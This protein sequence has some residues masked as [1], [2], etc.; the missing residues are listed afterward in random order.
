MRM[1]QDGVLSLHGGESFLTERESDAFQVLHGTVLVYIV[2]IKQ[3]RPGR[4]S[5]LYQAEER[6]VLPAFACRDLE[7]CDWRF[8]FTALERAELRRIEGGSTRVLRERFARKARVRNF[9]REGYNGGLVDQ[10]RF[11]IVT[12]DGFIR[13]TQHQKED[14]SEATLSLLLGA[15]RK[16]MP[17]AAEGSDAPVLYRALQLLCGS[18]KIP[19]VPYEKLKEAC[20]DGFTVADAARLSRFACREIVLEPGWERADGGSFLAFRDNGGPVVCLSRGTHRY[21]LWDV[22]NGCALPGTKE[23]HAALSPK[24][25]LLYPPLPSRSLTVRDLAR[26]CLGRIR[27]ADAVQL[28]LLTLAVSLLG[29]VTPSISQGIYDRYIP[30]GATDVLFQLG[31]LLGSFMIANILL[32]I[33]KNI[34]GYRLSSRMA[35]DAQSAIYAR[36]FNL[37]ESFFRRFESADLA[38]RVMTAGALVNNVAGVA[39]SAVVSLVT[40][41]VCLIRMTGCSPKLT[42][43]GVLMTAL[44]GALSYVISLRAL[45]HQARAAELGGKTGSILF[46]FLNGIAKIRIAGVEE[47][48]VY[49][50]LRPYVEERNEEEKKKKILDLGAVLNLIS[51]SL[52]TAVFYILIIRSGGGISLGAFLAFTTLFGTF[53]ACFLQLVD[54]LVRC[55]NERPALERLKPVLEA[56]PEFDEG[57]ELPG[58]LTGSIE[59]N[60]VSF[61]YDADAPLVLDGVS[62]NIR[63]GEYVG[64]VGA[65]GCGKSTLLKL[66]LGFET[67]TAG[68]IYYDNKDIESVDKRELRKK[69]GVVLQDGKLISG[70]IFENI[71]ITAPKA[72]LRD[73]NAV[74]AAVGLKDDIAAMPMGLHTILSE[75]CRTISGGQQQRILIARAL[76]GG[77]RILFFDEATSALDNVTQSMVCDALEKMD[78]TRVVIAHRLSTVIRCDRIVVLDRGRVAEQGSYDELMA[79]RGLFYQLASRQMV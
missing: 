36:L 37:P 1:N 23:V 48:A 59:I 46:Q 78:A 52:F 25:W 54:G 40:L 14:V 13:R 11:N 24:A 15:F 79:R 56:V 64:L 30:M 9:K 69:M 63:A 16:D 3:G 68:K 62:L 47:R 27:T 19:L 38:Q 21:L 74:V 75:D 73:V 65:S 29:I 18:Q 12:E 28:V 67:P 22:E 71:T 61:A 58:D 6:E 43:I 76:I 53:S 57:K 60:N 72:T 51:G 66:L 35:Y 34:A 33:V 45:R 10:Y 39:I 8:C 31:C 77:P 50:Y 49:E 41:L 20:G 44:Y 70:S 55:K 5:F 42:G 2:P 7:Y 4:R 32:S 26:F 17:A